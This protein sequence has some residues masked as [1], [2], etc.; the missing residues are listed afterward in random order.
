MA[1]QDEQF[2]GITK[3]L[4][5]EAPK[6]KDLELHD[7]LVAELKAQNNFEHPDITQKRYNT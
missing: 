6:P 2:K 3:P 7:A 4:S 5:T 1:D